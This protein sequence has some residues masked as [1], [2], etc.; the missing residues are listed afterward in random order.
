MS[1]PTVVVR[2]TPAMV[3]VAEEV[4]R[5]TWPR[6]DGA[7]LRQDGPG[8]GVATGDVDGL[9]AL[10]E[11]LDARAAVSLAPKDG[12]AR[13]LA[14]H[15]ANR[16]RVAIARAEERA[17]RP[18]IPT[19]IT[20]EE[21]DFLA[22]GSVTGHSALIDRL[23]RRELVERGT[24]GRTLTERGVGIVNDAPPAD[25]VPFGFFNLGQR[26]VMAFNVTGPDGHTFAAGSDVFVREKDDRR[27]RFVVTD[28]A[29][30][31]ALHDVHPRI[32]RFPAA[33]RAA[34]T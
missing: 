1:G 28:G 6:V 18:A 7:A 27:R 3:A 22:G 9:S 2:L 15:A 26:L 8:A 31:H 33:P 32:L 17:G 14:R 34:A 30:V 24:M 11:R 16:C 13:Q 23:E 5:A 19:T 4:L 12:A 21:F 29:G 25:L 10:A 20:T